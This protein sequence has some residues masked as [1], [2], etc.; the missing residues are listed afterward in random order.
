[1]KLMKYLALFSLA[2]LFIRCASLRLGEWKGVQA[3]KSWVRSK[4]F[5]SF[6][7]LHASIKGPSTGIPIRGPQVAIK[8]AT[9]TDVAPDIILHHFN[10]I[11]GQSQGRIAILGTSELNKNQQQVI[12]M[13]SY[14]L[15]LSGNHVYTSGGGDGTNIAVIR[16]ALRA[17]NPDLLTVMLPQSLDRQPGSMQ[18]LLKDVHNLLEQPENDGLGLREAAQ[19]C[20]YRLM[21]MV[22]KVIVFVYHDSATILNP[23]EEFEEVVEVVRFFLD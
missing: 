23:L 9:S 14:A 22:D 20:N 7:Q 6:P 2:L 18:I 8:P 3:G 17:G 5:L 11:Q 4:H 19:L 15:V 13:L 1:M 12:E 16:G 21:S 10:E